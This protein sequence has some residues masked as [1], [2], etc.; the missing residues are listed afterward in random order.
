M[1]SFN[2]CKMPCN[3]VSNRGGDLEAKVTDCSF[4]GLYGLYIY[5]LTKTFPKTFTFLT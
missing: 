1:R 5:M 4:K 3:F 2:A